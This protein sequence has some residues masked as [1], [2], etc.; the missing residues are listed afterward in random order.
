[1]RSVFYLLI[2]FLWCLSWTSCGFR[3]PAEADAL[4]TTAEAMDTLLG[5]S[6]RFFHQ[7]HYRQDGRDTVFS[8][9]GAHDYRIVVF[10]TPDRCNDCALRLGEWDLKLK[11]LDKLQLN[12]RIIFLIQHTDYAGFEHYAHALMP[13]R[14]FVYDTLGRFITANRLPDNVSYFFA[15]WSGSN[16]FGG[17]SFGEREDVGLV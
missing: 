2:L 14:P 16:C 7:D 8:D 3:S 4:R 9:N 6:I 15:R 12:P 5:R 17:F 10:A 13:G 11:E 1:M